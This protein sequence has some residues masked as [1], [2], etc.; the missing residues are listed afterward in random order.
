MQVIFDGQDLGAIHGLSDLA[1]VVASE[2][3]EEVVWAALDGVDFD[4]HAACEAGETPTAEQLELCTFEGWLARSAGRVRHVLQSLPGLAKDI[5]V[6]SEGVNIGDHITGSLAVVKEVLSDLTSVQEHLAP[7]MATAFDDVKHLCQGGEALLNQAIINKDF[8]CFADTLRM[9]W[10]LACAALEG[11]LDPEVIPQAP[12]S[13]PG[14]ECSPEA[15]YALN[16]EALEVRFP[17]IV[18]IVKRAWADRD[19]DRYGFDLGATGLRSPVINNLRQW[20][21]VCPD[22][23]SKA[24]AKEHKADN[25][26]KEWSVACT[27]GLPGDRAYAILHEERPKR[28]ILLVRMDLAGFA[29]E[30]HCVDL[31]KL[32]SDEGVIVTTDITEMRWALR[33]LVGESDA[34]RRLSCPSIMQI[35]PITAAD[36]HVQTFRTTMSRNLEAHT[37]IMRGREWA[38]KALINV[39]RLLSEPDLERLKGRY[40]GM[41]GLLVAPGPSLKKN[42]DL[43]PQFAEVGVVVGVSHVLGRLQEIGV[44]PELSVAIE[45]NDISFH[46][47]STDVEHASIVVSESSAPEVVSLPAAQFWV[48]HDSL[49]GNWLR[50]ENVMPP[51][52][53]A[54]S[55]THVVFHALR[56]M[57]CNPIYLVGLDLA[58][59]D[60]GRQYS[61]GCA[62]WTPN[63]ASIECEGYHGG[64]VQTIAQYNTFRD[65]FEIMFSTDEYQKLRIVN[66]TEGGAKIE[67]TEQ[68]T[69]A[70]ALVE[71]KDAPKKTHSTPTMEFEDAVPNPD[72]S[73]AADAIEAAA[74]D[75]KEAMKSAQ[76]AHRQAG[77]AMAAFRAGDE[78]RMQRKGRTAARLAVKA[79]QVITND[80]VLAQRW[81]VQQNEN[82]R[83]MEREA[84]YIEP[85]SAEMMRHNL[86]HYLQL[87]GGI[88][89][90]TRTL[91][92]HYRRCASAIRERFHV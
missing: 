76:K 32:L 19:P 66:C 30:M 88:E 27:F 47:D 1:E 37:G 13:E 54:S 75:L 89:E 52:M 60:D 71:L 6:V 68:M 3:F 92:P 4:L 77:E 17:L 25:C 29:A 72:W 8:V 46:F 65:Q 41:P 33:Y 23:D 86:T 82:T 28:P 90:G 20:S 7:E 80:F 38:E 91:E 2:Q 43:I 35:D 85:D 64:R 24:C 26:V 61:E 84:S 11:F 21:I 57:G 56:N 51:N 39:P 22:A 69:L 5:I 16:L 34:L 36:L 53:V 12:E 78:G 81:M 55:C 79:N 63:Q 74:D 18:D 48:M 14:P 83:R 50:E 67:H 42:I 45:A 87:L 15:L 31:T 10:S 49:V 58:L 70:E 44:N 73:G 9:E 62:G 59:A 40:E